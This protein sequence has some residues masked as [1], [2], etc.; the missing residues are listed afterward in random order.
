[1]DELDPTVHER[2]TAL[3]EQ[4]DE[5]A[6]AGQYQQAV[7]ALDHA[8]AMLPQPRTQWEAATWLLGSLGDMH[9]QFGGYAAGHE[10][11]TA[12]MHCP[13][14]VGNPF[15]HLR[16]GQCQLELGN[17][18]R[19]LDELMRAYM[20]GGAEMF[21]DEDSKYLGFLASRVPDVEPPGRRRFGR[22]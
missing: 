4:A 22:R 1:M 2:I 5:Y 19:A 15:L 3:G 18:Q 12:A 10:V 9:F 8:W 7:A 16:L 13:G 17:E 11:L 20:G 6:E 14:A 21:E